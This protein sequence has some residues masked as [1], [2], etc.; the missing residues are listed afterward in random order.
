MTRPLSHPVPDPSGDLSALLTA[1][2][3]GDEHAWRT[4]LEL[5][6]RRVFALAK[7]RVHRS[8]LAEE[9]TQ[10]V[11]FTVASKLKDGGYSE[12]GRFE[13]WLFRVAMNRVRD[14]LRREHRHARPTDPDHFH[15][16]AVAEPHPSSAPGPA[17]LG[18]LRAAME[19]LAAP[20]RE[21]IELRHHAGL[22][23]NQIAAVLQEP[24]G[25]V[26]ARHHRALRK[27]KDLLT[28]GAAAQ[29]RPPLRSTQED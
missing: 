7:S 10:S 8:D 13:Q 1:A 2:G 25:T 20:D 19:Q 29:S 16:I 27:L 28:P 23:F 24:L 6:A 4:V 5:Y 11:F 9:V 3:H 26:L 17:S 18:A 21:V 22:T 15:G 12:R 14:E